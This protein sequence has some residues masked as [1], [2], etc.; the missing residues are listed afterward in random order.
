MTTIAPTDRRINVNISLPVGAW[1]IKQRAILAFLALRS[2]AV[3]VLNPPKAAV[4]K[5]ADIP[6]TVAGLAC[7]DFAAFHLAHGWGWLVTG[8]SLLL[9]EFMASDE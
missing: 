4:S 8:L 2:V 5:L 1:R 6:L 3:V 9:L 7:V